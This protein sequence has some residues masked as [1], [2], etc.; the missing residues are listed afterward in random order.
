VVT[1]NTGREVASGTTFRV[2]FV[3]NEMYPER[4]RR[5]GQLALANGGGF[6]YLRG[7]R[8]SPWLAAE[9]VVA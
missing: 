7:D 2:N 5:A 8:E 4:V 3:V 9:A 6:V 1:V